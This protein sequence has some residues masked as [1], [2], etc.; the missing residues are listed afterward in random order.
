[1]WCI[2]TMEYYKAIKKKEILP[3]Q[4]LDEHVNYYAKG[5]KLV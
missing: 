2:Y 4:Q 3:L 1:M 5:N